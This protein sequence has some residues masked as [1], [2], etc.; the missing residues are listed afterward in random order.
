MSEIQGSTV[1]VAPDTRKI[2]KLLQ[3]G[4]ISTLSHS[5]EYTRR[6]QSALLVPSMLACALTS[7][8]TRDGILDKSLVKALS[9]FSKTA[10]DT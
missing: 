2:G 10:S 4:S 7:P 8:R 6:A 3:A 1:E 5:A 9:R